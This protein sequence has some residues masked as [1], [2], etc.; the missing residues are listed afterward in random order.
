MNEFFS[1]NGQRFVYEKEVKQFLINLST[2][3]KYPFSTPELRE[4]L[5]HTFW[6]VGNRV[7]SVKALERLLKE[8]PIFKDYEII[9]AA[10]NGKSFEEEENDFYANE[11]SYN[12]SYKTID[13]LTFF[14]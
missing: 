10:G 1:T 4:E 9:I 7:N 5:K 2:N 6:Y 3:K 12:S 8:D 11:S 14:L 13:S